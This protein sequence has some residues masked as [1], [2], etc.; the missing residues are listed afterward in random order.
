MARRYQ[1]PPA[2]ARASAQPQETALW[3]PAMEDG[4]RASILLRQ[5]GDVELFCPSGTGIRL[6]EEFQAVILSGKRLKLFFDEIYFYA[7]PGQIYLNDE[8]IEPTRPHELVV[9]PEGGVFEIPGNT[10][11]R[12]PQQSQWQTRRERAQRAVQTMMEALS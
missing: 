3:G 7:L 1:R 11:L 5:D 4:G 10:A 12:N 8:P 9:P 6:D 2:E